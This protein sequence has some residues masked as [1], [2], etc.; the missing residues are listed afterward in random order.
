[1]AARIHPELEPLV[2]MFVNTL[3]LRA[4]P[5]AEKPFRA[6][7][8]EV[9]ADAQEAADRQEFPLEAMLGELPIERHPGRT[10]LYETLFVLQNLD[11]PAIRSPGLEILRCDL[12]APAAKLDLSL[13]AEERSD[14]LAFRFEYRTALFSRATLES[15]AGEYLAILARAAR[16][17]DAP[18]KDLPSMGSRGRR[19]AG[20]ADEI[21]FSL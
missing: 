15:M 20:I 3:V 1:M 16:D 18:M 10:P 14:G 5:A 19:A 6:F 7:L 17:P 2:G 21:E 11:L 8:A 13:F 9:A 4:H 12:E